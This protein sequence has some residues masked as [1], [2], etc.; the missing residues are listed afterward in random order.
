MRKVFVD[1]S[2]LVAYFYNKDENHLEAKRILEKIKKEKAVM[3]I[4]DYIFDECITGIMSSAG[5][6]S[7]V[8]AGE[9]IFSSNIIKMIWLDESIKF[10]SWDF[11]KKYSDKGFS[12]TDCT[13][14]VLMKDLKVKDY[15]AFDED[16]KRAG[17]IE[18]SS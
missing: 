4:T 3:L 6:N 7:A 8:A 1:T 13:S 11:F 9:Y 18:F 5:H 16:F 2:A 14:F 10:K 12:F 15:F 17:F